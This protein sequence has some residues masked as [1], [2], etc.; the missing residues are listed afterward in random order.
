[1]LLPRDE[2]DS[3]GARK[4]LKYVEISGYHGGDYEEYCPLGFDAVYSGRF[5]D[6]IS[7]TTI[8]FCNSFPPG[9][10]ATYL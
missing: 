7:R 10:S 5:H 3:Q 2:S 1:V 4:Q 9:F 6:A 8:L